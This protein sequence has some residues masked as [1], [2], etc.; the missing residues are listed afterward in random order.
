[1]KE[2]K[3]ILEGEE[4]TQMKAIALLIQK[5]SAFRSN[6]HIQSGEKR[7]NA[8]SL[9]GLMTLG[10]TAGSEICLLIDGPD[11]EEAMETLRTWLQNPVLE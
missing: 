11:E 9:L 3:I 1:M 5:A 8:K 6:I 10:L 2:C 4:S 7:A